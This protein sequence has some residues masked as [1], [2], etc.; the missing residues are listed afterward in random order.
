MKTAVVDV[1][2]GLR[3][4]YACGVLD[5]CM[6]DGVAFDV[7]VGVSAGAANIASYLA[8]QKGRN[9]RFYT[10]YSRRREYMSLGNFLRKG[11]YIDMDYVYGELSRHDGEDPLDYDALEKGAAEM[12]VVATNALTGEAV[13]FTKKDLTPD[14]YDVVKASC[15]IPFVCHP[16]VIQGTPYYDGA[17][18]DP[19]PIEKAFSMGCDKVVLLLTKPKDLRRTPE[20]DCF[21]AKR[22]RRK[23]PK[24]ADQLERRASHYNRGVDLASMYQQQ[25]KLL[26]VAPD[27]TCGVDTL[28]RDRDALKRLY[29]KG[30]QDGGQIAD[31]VKKP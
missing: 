9:Y 18:G 6:E 7:G 29:E 15:S 2:G 19:I 4:I 13:Y 28:T 8:G 21:L 26:V 5:R 1:G 30:F 22:I 16:Y 24:A 11:S 25:G 3:G 27:D 12:V 31:F 10:E 23:Y 17:L 20:K 14:H